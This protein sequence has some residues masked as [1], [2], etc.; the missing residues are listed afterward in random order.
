MRKIW[1]HFVKNLVGILRARG[2]SSPGFRAFV[3]S[4]SKLPVLGNFV[5]SAV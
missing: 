3:D 2:R 1:S 5:A 4:A